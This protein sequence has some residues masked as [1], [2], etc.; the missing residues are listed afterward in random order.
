MKA[1]RLT[2]LLISMA[3]MMGLAQNNE[4]STNNKLGLGVRTSVFQISDFEYSDFPPNRL[5]INYDPI[6]HL[7][8]EAQFGMYRSDDNQNA[9]STGLRPIDQR[10]AYALGLHYIHKVDRIKFAAGLRYLISDFSNEFIDFSAAGNKIAIDREKSSGIG[11]VLGGEY[12]LAKWFSVGAEI[13]VNSSEMKFTPAATSMTDDY[14]KN[15]TL[16]ESSVLFRFYP[17]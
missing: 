14:T 5:M 16:T 7:R 4:T 17:F 3:P 1:I 13:A 15:I 8:I 11:V 9:G 6:E 12:F 2:L 10:Y